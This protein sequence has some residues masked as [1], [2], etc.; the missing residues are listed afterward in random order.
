[1]ARLTAVSGLGKKAAAL[2][3]IETE[4][5]RIL[6][7]FGA[8]LEAGDR[9]NLSAIGTVDAVV[10]SHCHIDHCGSLPR[11]REVGLPPVYATQR[12]F[13]S[14]PPS[15]LPP[16]RVILPERGQ[17]LLF[18]DLLTT[19]RSGH[20]PGGVWLHLTTE[21]G[22][23]L[24]TGDVCTE[25]AVFPLDPLP[26]AGTVII[27][28]SYGD[29][30]TPLRAQIPALVEAARQGAVLCTPTA[31]RG[32]D[33]VHHLRQAG[34]SPVVCNTIGKEVR[35]TTGLTVPCVTVE[36]ARPDQIIV[37]TSANAEAGLAAAL[38]RRGDFRFIFSSHVPTTSPAHELIASGN[39]QWLGWNVHPTRTEI[40]ALADACQARKVLPAFID[41][42]SA[43][44]LCADLG[45]R[46]WSHAQTEV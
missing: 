22:G 3:L 14:L 21:F 26:G 44:R 29:R 5:K 2:F 15:T 13:D 38:L 27:D 8:S 23:V 43:P 46:L 9:C 36:T 1:M 6:F 31:G 32:P 16:N 42:K 24:Y 45:K 4:D 37:T 17:I 7:D 19:G 35:H 40:L 41:L 34:L 11:L 39:A 25:S 30:E 18:G 20:A 10:L 28:A 33:M 12:T